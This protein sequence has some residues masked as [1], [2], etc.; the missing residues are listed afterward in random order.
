MTE[1][2]EN[3][4]INDTETNLITIDQAIEDFSKIK[5]KKYLSFGIKKIMIN[6]ILEICISENESGLK[7]VDYSLL[8]LVKQ[9]T[10]VNNYTNIDFA[11]E[12]TISVFDR[13]G[14]NNVIVYILNNIDKEELMFFDVVLRQEIKQIKELDNSIQGVLAKGLNKLIE[15]LP[16]EKGIAKII[17][18]LPKQINK[19]NPDKMQFIKNALDWNN[20]K[21]KDGE[22]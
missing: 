7:V 21:F 20:G 18:D 4:N 17:K 9:F 12:D 3:K 5:F 2:I 19:I 14:E 6:K 10:L 16:D 15:K 1:I 13:L 11:L 22:K 8:S